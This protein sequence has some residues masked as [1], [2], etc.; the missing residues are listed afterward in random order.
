MIYVDP[1]GTWVQISRRRK[2]EVQKELC[3]V[4]ESVH[5][6]QRLPIQLLERL[7]REKESNIQW[8]ISAC[9]SVATPLKRAANPSQPLMGRTSLTQITSNESIAG[10]QVSNTCTLL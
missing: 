9:G 1:C 7:K 2:A 8:Y 4:A 5:H 10:F 6:F 3:G